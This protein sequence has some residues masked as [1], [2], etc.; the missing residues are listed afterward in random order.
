MRLSRPPENALD[1]NRR[2]IRILIPPTSSG[3][4]AEPATGTFCS[5]ETGRD[6]AQP[7]A[8]TSKLFEACSQSPRQVDRLEH[9]KASKGSQFG[10]LYGESQIRTRFEDH[11]AIWTR[12][13][14]AS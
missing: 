13:I 12:Q 6:L 3:K 8:T 14:S 7:E 2:G 4:P 10:E 1:V 9:L 5:M 11:Q